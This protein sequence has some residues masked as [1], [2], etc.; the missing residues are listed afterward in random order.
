[1]PLTISGEGKTLL[2][3]HGYLSCKESFIYQIEYFSRFFKVVVPDMAGFNGTEMP[4]PYALAD[5]ARDVKRLIDDC[6]GK[7]DV[8]AHSFGARVLFKLLPHEKV[9]RIV[10]TGAAGLRPKRSL[11]KAVAV[12]RYKIRKKLKLDVSSFGSSDYK[13][14]SPIMRE[15]FVK[16]VN[17]RLKKSI[18]HVANDCLLVFG[19]N[20]TETP[21]YMAKRLNKYLKNSSLVLIKG[22]GH[23][24]FLEKPNQ[25]NVIVKEFLT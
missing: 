24:A 23:F 4:Y 6:D 21:L 25:F 2:M 19:E 7:V 1:M 20:D 13:A 18:K 17:E 15:S 10:L 14:L 8:I 9:D 12:F 16:I 11:K 22:A 3:L 5:Y